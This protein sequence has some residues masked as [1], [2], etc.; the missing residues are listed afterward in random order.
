[1]QPGQRR[2]RALEIAVEVAELPPRDHG[3]GAVERPA[4]P[5]QQVRQA[6]IHHDRPRGIGDLDQGA[7][8]IEEQR[9]VGTRMRKSHAHL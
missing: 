2:H 7:V 3:E 1:V 5:A 4:E 8:E 9:P 6:R